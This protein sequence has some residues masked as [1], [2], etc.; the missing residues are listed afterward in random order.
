MARKARSFGKRPK[1]VTA[2]RRQDGKIVPA[3]KTVIEP[4]GKVIRT[5]RFNGKNF[6]PPSVIGTLPE[7]DGTKA[8]KQEQEQQEIA[9]RSGL[10]IML[11]ERTT[12]R[13]RFLAYWGNQGVS[14]RRAVKDGKPASSDKGEVY[15]ADGPSQVLCAMLHDSRVQG[16]TETSTCQGNSGSG[17]FFRKPKRKNSDQYPSRI[18][19]YRTNH[20]FVGEGKP[21]TCRI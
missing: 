11:P 13:R 12:I 1:P 4:D 19:V 5:F 14:F 16:F 17:Q 6:I 8:I 7:H 10:T 9:P 15:Y 18:S 20:Q 3:V 21:L 2:N